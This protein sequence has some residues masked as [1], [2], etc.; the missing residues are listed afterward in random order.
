MTG[1]LGC[2]HKHVDSGRRLNLSEVNI[3]PVTECQKRAVFQMRSNFIP[4][5]G[6]LHFVRS[7]DHDHVRLFHGI[8]HRHHFQTRGFGLFPGRTFA[9]PDDN[10][11]AALRQIEGM[12]VPLTAE[13]D[14]RHFLFQNVL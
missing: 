4:I 12:G 8:G 9:Q 6:R 5:D 14:N 11:H 10:V 3:K 1:S 2:H 7:Q 13:P